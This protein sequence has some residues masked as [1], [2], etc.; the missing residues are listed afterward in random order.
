M[1]RNTFFVVGVGLFLGCAS[2]PPPTATPVATGPDQ[3][4]QEVAQLEKNAAESAAP[5]PNAPLC[6][7]AVVQHTEKKQLAG[8]PGENKPPSTI[9]EININGD[10]DLEL[11]VRGPCERGKKCTYA[12]F[13]ACGA[14]KFAHVPAEG[15]VGDGLETSRKG[16]LF[17][18]VYYRDIILLEFQTKGDTLDEGR[19]RFRF[20]GKGYEILAK[21]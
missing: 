7:G 17:D 9:K 2:A 15:L 14:G 19:T 6:K 13:M 3:A 1:A 5:D 12:V 11:F 20:N 8:F 10:E 4:P 18:G 16:A 21:N